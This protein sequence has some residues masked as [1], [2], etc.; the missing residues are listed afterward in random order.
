MNQTIKTMLEQMDV[1]RPKEPCT[2]LQVANGKIVWFDNS[3]NMIKIQVKG[4]KF[5]GF[6]TVAYNV[7]TDYY[8]VTF[9]SS[10]G[11]QKQEFGLDFEQLPECLWNET[12][13]V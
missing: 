7:G 10:K 12:F 4:D 13:I 11:E 9:T 8:D 1:K 5:A 3:E 2:Y 6:I